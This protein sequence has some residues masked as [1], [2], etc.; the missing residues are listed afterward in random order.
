MLGSAKLVLLWIGEW[1][2]KAIVLG[3]SGRSCRGLPAKAVASVEF[4]LGWST[5][6]K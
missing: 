1:L 5:L 2:R 4:I 6:L 3:M